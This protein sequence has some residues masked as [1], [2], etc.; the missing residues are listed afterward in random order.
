MTDP[1]GTGTCSDMTGTT[2]TTTYSYADSYS[3]G[4]PPGQ[5][6]AYLTKVTDPLNHFT[7]FKYGYNDGQLT[8]STDPNIQP[9]SYIYNTPPSGCSYLDK[10]DRLS[11]I[12]YPDG[13]KTTF[14]YNDSVPSVTTTRLIGSSSSLITTTS[15]DGLGHPVLSQLTSDPLGTVSTA[16]A[17]DGLG[18]TYQSWNPTRCSPPTT[19]CGTGGT[20]T[21]WGVTTYLYDALGRTTQVKEQDSSTVATN[22]SAFPCTTA[23]DEA[24]KSRKSCVD[25]LGRMTLVQEDP[26]GLN[27]KTVYAYDSLNNLLSVT[28]NGSNSA[29]ARIRTFTYDSL[30]R[31]LCAANPEVELV[32]CPAAPPFP[33][34]A[35]AYTYDNNGNVTQ[36]KAPLPNQT[37]ASQVTTNY[38][39]D[40][41]NRLVQKS[42]TGM[43]GQPT[44]RF[45]YDGVP[46]SGCTPTQVSGAT[47]LVGRR[48]SMCD[49]AGSAAWS[50]DAM[51][52]ALEE[53]RLTNGITKRFSYSYFED[54]E[55]GSI[56]YP[57]GEQVGFAPYGNGLPGYVT[58]SFT[59]DIAPSYAPNGALANLQAGPTSNP[60]AVS[61]ALFYNNRFQQAEMYALDSK[62]SY[63]AQYCYDFH[64]Q[65]G[66]TI[67]DL[68]F[69][70][71]FTA[72]SPANNGNLY[73]VMNNLATGRTQN[74][75]YDSLNRIQ[76]AQTSGP[77]WG[78]AYTID[79]WGNLT[80][81]NSYQGK[82]YEGL[83]CGPANSKNQLNTCYGYDAAG[84]LT[85][86]GSE[87]YT[88]D[89]ENRLITAGG[90][91]YTY[92]GDGKRVMKSNGTVY[93]WGVGD[94]VLAESNLSGT[95]S[96]E[97]AYLN[98]KR[99]VRMDRPSGKA[100]LYFSDLVG[101]ATMITDINGNPEKQ[102]DYYP[103]GGEIPISGTDPN[104]Y[105]FTGKERDTES[106]LDYF[107]ARHYASTMGRFMTPDL[108]DDVDRPG[109][110]PFADFRDP[111]TLNLYAYVRNNPL[112]RVDPDGHKMT[113][114]TDDQGNMHCVV[115]PDPPPQQNEPSAIDLFRTFL[116]TRGA[117]PE[118]RKAI[119]WS[120]FGQVF[121]GNLGNINDVLPSQVANS[122]FGK[123]LPN[124]PLQ[125]LKVLDAIDTSGTTPTN[126][127]SN[128]RNFQ[129]DGRDGGQVLPP[130]DGSGNGVTYREWDVN[131]RGPGG[132][133]AERIV[134]GSDGSAYYTT[135][136]YRTFQKIR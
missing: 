82:P 76:T 96:E 78:E 84:N 71:D 119:M 34:G 30:S 129:N 52:R 23:T 135:D 38:G 132:R 83:N 14:C 79:A 109:P 93:W 75:V 1:C 57:D 107:G 103:Y 44:I 131:P 3:S 121:R 22:Y 26:S 122:Q 19:N 47:N 136:H 112:N 100:N 58:D 63:I 72:T 85:K 114:T 41:L 27:Y 18:R 70:C 104:H 25:G 91:T 128:G 125:A 8:S 2:H 40:A 29:I 99:M 43:S 31:L 113:C 51:G 67:G 127:P 80:A 33:A 54:G 98:G 49:G 87:I 4:T 45:G 24:G 10:L 55:P 92:D 90:V 60:G 74:F 15:M 65:G 123:S 36:K 42:F 73:Q 86:N 5:T 133:G 39:Y 50:Y 61:Q 56:L 28:Q 108:D 134:T 118:D 21:S 32:T 64:V 89:A 7:T 111:Q 66:T 11:E 116:N 68:N 105:K 20:E 101:S 6:N 124:I 46:P 16:R 35:I 130:T 94:D 62:S 53:A 110:M 17:Y 37:G 97:Y 106:N 81:I 117:D 77:N 126:V 120:M 69:E 12:D 88:Y 102:S 13:G 48:S 9:T 95:I 59:F 115:T